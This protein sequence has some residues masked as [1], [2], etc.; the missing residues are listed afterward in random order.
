MKY[1]VLSTAIFLTALSSDYVMSAESSRE[2]IEL[3]Q[4]SEEESL[5]EVDSK[6]Q[7]ALASGDILK[8]IKYYETFLKAFPNSYEGLVYLGGIYGKKK[9]FKKEIELCNRAIRLNPSLALGHVNLGTAQLYLKKWQEA[10][11]SF[12]TGY[13]YAQMNK[14]VRSLQGASY[15]LSNYYLASP[16]S[17]NLQAIKWA[18]ICISHLPECLVDGRGLPKGFGDL[19]KQDNEQLMWIYES[20]IMN[21]AGAHANMNDLKTARIILEEYLQKYPES[22]DVR[23]M[24]LSLEGR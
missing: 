3:K 13:K 16:D 7:A 1:Q 14:D 23:V 21:K 18:D 10:E 15:S 11:K 2:A 6:A 24:L 8:A 17:D 22:L 4:K 19:L 5:H 9:D 12:L 20:A